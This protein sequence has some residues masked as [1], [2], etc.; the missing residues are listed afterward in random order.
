M[1]VY[2]K[3]RFR[4][5]LGCKTA[6]MVLAQSQTM[7]FLTRVECGQIFGALVWLSEVT[8]I[9]SGCCEMK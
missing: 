6:A 5:G 9:K 7:F 8:C 3:F 4:A 1:I 2:F